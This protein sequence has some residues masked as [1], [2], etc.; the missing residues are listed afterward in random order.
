[1]HSRHWAVSVARISPEVRPRR[2]V[3][4][5][6]RRDIS[7]AKMAILKLQRVRFSTEADNRLRMLKARSGL[8][9]NIICRFGA[10][11][12]ARGA[13]RSPLGFIWAEST[14][15]QPLHAVR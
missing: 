15:N 13:R 11:P 12:V 3:H 6:R 9:N 4:A 1:M 14:R 5:R 7:G 8:D 10:V 2:A